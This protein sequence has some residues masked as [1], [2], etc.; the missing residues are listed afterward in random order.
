MDYKPKF[1]KPR[2]DMEQ[3]VEYLDKHI[4]CGLTDLNNGFDVY[5]NR[6]FSEAEF[7]IVLDRVEKAG[8][9]IFGI[10]PWIDGEFYDVWTCEDFNDDPTNPLWYR[11][12]FEEFVSRGLELQYLATYFVPAELPD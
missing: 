3:Q 5:I 2:K 10:E 7:R 11:L 9:G 12:A 4:F 8:L 6:Y 1:D